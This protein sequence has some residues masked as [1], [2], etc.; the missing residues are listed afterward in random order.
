MYVDELTSLSMV[1]E[2]SEI[3]IGVG[4]A[5]VALVVLAAL[6]DAMVFRSERSVLRAVRREPAVASA[7]SE[8]LLAR[9]HFSRVVAKYEN[10]IASQSRV[11]TLT[12]DGI[13]T[14]GLA[15]EP[16][17]AEIHPEVQNNAGGPEVERLI[18]QKSEARQ[19]LVE[20]Q[21]LW[22][23]VRPGALPAA[24]ANLWFGSGFMR[25]WQLGPLGFERFYYRFDH[26]VDPSCWAIFEASRFRF[27]IGLG[28]E[29][30]TLAL[31]AAGASADELGDL[32]GLAFGG[33][34]VAF[35]PGF[36]PM[37]T[38]RRARRSPHAKAANN[39]LLQSHRVSDL[40]DGLSP[41]ARSLAIAAFE[42]ELGESLTRTTALPDGP[43]LISVI[44]KGPS[45]LLGAWAGRTP[46]PKIRGRSD[47]GAWKQ[48]R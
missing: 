27:G 5:I 35:R 22:D 46:A 36:V 20:A 3:L 30:Q 14:E 42:V 2:A 18:M 7:V 10:A 26:A 21:N 1:V 29:T 45:F 33:P 31:F 12:S 47:H 41:K 28:A 16:A 43:A 34:E 24:A 25:A 40:T 48:R 23:A 39:A 37:R 15:H 8:I 6:G 19:R 9:D 32:S 38:W 4:A 13:A 17:L 44:T 11:M